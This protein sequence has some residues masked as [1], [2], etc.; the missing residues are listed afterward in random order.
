MKKLIRIKR[1]IIG[2][3][4]FVW[5][6]PKNWKSYGWEYEDMTNFYWSG[7]TVKFHKSQKSQQIKEV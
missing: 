6:F 7:K 3:Y 5:D 1:F 2:L 4:R